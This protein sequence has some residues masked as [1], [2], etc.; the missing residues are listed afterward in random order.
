MQLSFPLVL[1]LSLASVTLSQTADDARWDNRFAVAGVPGNV[2]AMAF[3]KKRIYLGG[4]VQS[5]GRVLADAVAEFDGKAWRA[6]PDGP[7]Q[8]PILLNVLA[9]EIFNNRLYV[10]GFFTNVGGVPAGGFASWHGNHWSVPGGTNGVVYALKAD[11]RSLLVAGRFTLPGYTNPVAL[12]RYDKHG[13]WQVLNSELPPTGDEDLVSVD[14]IDQ[15]QVLPNGDLVCSIAFAIREWWGGFSYPYYHLL[16][17]Y[18]AQL[19]WTDFSGPDGDPVGFGDYVLTRFG[20]TLIAAGSFTNAMNSTL[21]NIAQW[22]GSQWQPLGDGLEGEVYA[23]AGNDHVLY[24]LHRRNVATVVGR[25]AVSRW[26]GQ[27]WTR[28]GVLQSTDPYGRLFVGSDEDVYASGFFSGLD[29]TVAPGVAHWN[30]KEWEPLVKGTHAGVAGIINTVF[31]FAEHQGS[32]YMGGIFLS[33]GHSFSDGLARWDGEK[34]HDV[35]GGL[36][37][38]FHRI[39]ALASSGDRLFASGVFTNLGGVPANNV[40]SWDGS[41]WE[42]LGNGIFGTVVKLVWWRSNLYAGGRFYLADSNAVENIAQWDGV[43]WQSVGGCNSNVNALVE[44]RGDLYAGGRFTSAGGVAVSQLAKWDGVH[45]SDVGGGVGGNGDDDDEAGPTVSA[46]GVGPDGLYV[47]GQFTIVGSASATNIARWDG[48]N[49]HALGLGWSGTVTAIAVQERQVFVGGSVR[50]E[51]GKT[52]DAI[53]RWDG[54]NWNSLGSGISDVRRFNVY[55]LLARENDLFVG[56]RFATAGGKPSGS[57]A[58]WVS[59]PRI[60]VV[61]DTHGP[62]RHAQIFSEPGLRFRLETSTDLRNWNAV[63][64][65]EESERK[66]DGLKIGQRFFRGVLER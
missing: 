11:Q 6:L 41:R 52:I 64:E 2:T 54:T 24:A 47:G 17:R 50:D 61:Q 29:S 13:N 63:N 5:I 43:T 32:V 35:S 12:A 49:W 4:T 8:D 39:R 51:S 48:T 37:T 57:V 33:A 45:W 1:F 44:W 10:G 66:I 55:A 40:A 58:R 19:G 22:D 25:S 65:D 16:A 46:F 53:L 7:Q 15:V 31:A 28:I 56:G 18:D 3:D 27:Q 42:A 62:N 38:W 20:N 59:H 30:G 36:G 60:R 21:Q 9:L 26:E 34:W 23:V 14:S